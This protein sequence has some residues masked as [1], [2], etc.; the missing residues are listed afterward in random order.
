V[1][2]SLVPDFF[3]S[4]LQLV[5]TSKNSMREGIVVVVAFSLCLLFCFFCSHV[6]RL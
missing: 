1:S 4:N 3:F 6:S 2:A 5:F